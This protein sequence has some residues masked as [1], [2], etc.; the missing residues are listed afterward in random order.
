MTK[1]DFVQHVTEALKQVRQAKSFDDLQ[2]AIDYFHYRVHVLE[3]QEVLPDNCN[4]VRCER[5]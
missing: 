4:C 3:G 5:A 2:D 1:T